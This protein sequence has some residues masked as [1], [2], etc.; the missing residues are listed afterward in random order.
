MEL[1]RTDAV[2]FILRIWQRCHSIS[3]TGSDTARRRKKREHP[4]NRRAEAALVVSLEGT[5][6][7]SIRLPAHF[8]PRSDP[9]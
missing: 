8:M 6:I 2:G 5:L 1:F 9:H 7:L 3:L 4:G